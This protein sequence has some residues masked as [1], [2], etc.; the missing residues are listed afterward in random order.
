MKQET[1]NELHR[2]KQDIKRDYHTIGAITVWPIIALVF[3]MFIL[4]LVF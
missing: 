2:M 1:R 4:A 3:I